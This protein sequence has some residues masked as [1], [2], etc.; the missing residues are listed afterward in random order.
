MQVFIEKIEFIYSSLYLVLFLY[1]SFNGTQPD[2]ETLPC[3]YEKHFP[4]NVKSLCKQFF[5]VRQ[6]VAIGD[7]KQIKVDE[8]L[9]PSHCKCVVHKEI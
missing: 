5:G 3:K 4:Q 2:Q 9:F 8:F 6:L 1:S 7:D